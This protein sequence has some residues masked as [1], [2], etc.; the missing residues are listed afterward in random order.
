LA[1]YPLPPPWS[2]ADPSCS[3]LSFSPRWTY[4]LG[5]VRHSTLPT[6]LSASGGDDSVSAFPAA[7]LFSHLPVRRPQPVLPTRS[8][9]SRFDFPVP[10]SGCSFR[11][12]KIV[13]EKS[14]GIFS[15]GHLFPPPFPFP[16]SPKQYVCFFR[17]ETSLSP[18]DAFSVLGWPPA[19]CLKEY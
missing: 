11:C 16:N 12:F 18:F 13:P 15:P 5:A 8:E 1:P 14:P 6:F 10:P 19:F 4:V 9:T 2:Y 3:S 7:L 17:F